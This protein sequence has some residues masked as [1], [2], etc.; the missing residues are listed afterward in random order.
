M[1]SSTSPFRYEEVNGWSSTRVTPTQSRRS[2]R[3]RRSPQCTPKRKEVTPRRKYKSPRHRKS[4]SKAKSSFRWDSSSPRDERSTRR[5]NRQRGSPGYRTRVDLEEEEE[6]YWR[7]SGKRKEW[8]KTYPSRD[9]EKRGRSSRDVPRGR[10]HSEPV[11]WSKACKLSEE[12]PD[13]R[14]YDI[15]A[16]GGTRDFVKWFEKLPPNWTV[17]KDVRTDRGVFKKDNF[18]SSRALDKYLGIRN[19]RSPTDRLR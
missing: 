8:T 13:C 1:S 5:K 18:Q 11:G 7:D 17:D 19:S 6:L 3:R 2:E 12:I 15:E 16:R 9:D 4:K 10:Y 14:L